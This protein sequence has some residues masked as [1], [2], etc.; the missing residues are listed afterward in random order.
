MI[1]VAFMLTED[2]V[3]Q[4]RNGSVLCTEVE[5]VKADKIRDD[6]DR[7]SGT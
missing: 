2:V 6:D 4:M 7:K 3:L 1:Y 5:A